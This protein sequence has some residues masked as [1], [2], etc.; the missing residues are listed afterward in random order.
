MNRIAWPFLPLLAR[1]GYAVSA[2][3][4]D[5][6]RAASPVKADGVLD[7]LFRPFNTELETLFT[8]LLFS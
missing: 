6:G 5:I 8:Q 1:P 3:K 7:E 4:F 2:R